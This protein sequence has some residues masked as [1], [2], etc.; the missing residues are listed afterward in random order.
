MMNLLKSPRFG[1]TDRLNDTTALQECRAKLDAI[2]SSQAVIEFELDGTIITANNNFLA[3]LGYRLE[4]I[5][6]QHH[7]LFVSREHRESSDYRNFWDRLGKG[8][9]FHEDFSRVRK[10]GSEVWVRA[11]YYP[12]VGMDGKLSKV[13]KYANDIT[14]DV[15]LRQQTESVYEAVSGSIT[16]M[17]ETISEISQHVNQCANLATNTEIE[18]GTTS[19]SVGKLEQ[20][21]Q[22]IEKVVEVIRSLAAQTNLLAL[23]ATIESARAGEAGKGF[24]VVANEVKE[25]AKQTEQ[26]TATIDASVTDIRQ[27]IADSVAST[28]SVTNSIRSVTESMTS[29]SAAVEEQS[30][31]MIQLRETTTGLENRM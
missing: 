28:G 1:E 23:N 24:A 29:V 19:E 2:S 17:A 11:V 31:T 18:V 12:I 30:I 26:A 10:D 6:G 9:S 16:Q 13:V 8:E 4:E 27:L 20:S 5:V 3:T 14:D 21:S 25:L 22:V 7:S 15:L